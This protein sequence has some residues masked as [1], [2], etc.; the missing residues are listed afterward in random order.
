MRVRSSP[1]ISIANRTIITLKR[2]RE[3]EREVKKP[4]SNNTQSLSPSVPIRICPIAGIP[5]IVPAPCLWSRSEMRGSLRL[6]FL[7]RLRQWFL[8]IFPLRCS[9]ARRRMN[10]T[11]PYD[12]PKNQ[13]RQY[14]TT[15]DQHAEARALGALEVCLRELANHAA[16]VRGIC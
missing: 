7:T 14:D 8:L 15:S 5:I 2:E 4:E 12:H 9:V 6:T 1:A 11:Y 13:K 3:R 16:S 10:Q